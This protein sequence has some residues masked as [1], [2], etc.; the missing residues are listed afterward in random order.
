MTTELVNS[1]PSTHASSNPAIAWILDARVH[2]VSEDPAPFVPLPDTV[3][4]SLESEVT[5]A[6][7]MAGPQIQAPNNP[8]TAAVMQSL[9]NAGHTHTLSAG[10]WVENDGSFRFLRPDSNR[11]IEISSP[12]VS[13]GQLRN[14]TL[15]TM[16]VAALLLS[17]G[18]LAKHEG[19]IAI[20]S[21]KDLL[22]ALNVTSY[23]TRRHTI[24]DEVRRSLTFLNSLRISCDG[25][26]CIRRST[27]S[28]DAER[29]VHLTPIDVPE[30]GGAYNDRWRLELGIWVDTYLAGDRLRGFHWT[31][32]IPPVLFELDRRHQRPSE[33]I[34]KKIGWT[35]LVFSGGTKIFTE[36]QQR[37]RVQR[38]LEAIGELPHPTCRAQDWSRRTRQRLESALSF[39]EEKDVFT[40]AEYE[41]PPSCSGS[42][43]KS[44]LQSNLVFS[45]RPQAPESTT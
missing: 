41:R 3:S 21:M 28:C 35:V 16:D 44:W 26:P 24:A 23:G 32:S 18:T 20:L 10:R 8:L 38:L 25:L 27:F 36:V 42:W 1:A 37:F 31:T 2:S 39:L 17:L 6:E 14:N 30:N 29:F 15:I 45:T 34:A 40:R 19:A 43:S 7:M 4:S 13:F 11:R 9:A 12:S 5:L 22:S 33:G